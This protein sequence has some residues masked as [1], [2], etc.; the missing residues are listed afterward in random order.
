M[1]RRIVPNFL[2]TA[3][4]AACILLEGDASSRADILYVTNFGSDKIEKFTSGGSASV[5][6]SSG[7]SGP[8]GISF[9][10]TGNLFA[11]NLVG[12]TIEKYTLGVPSVFASGLN[13]P[14]G[15]AF[16]ATGNLYVANTGDR[17]IVKF[18]PGGARSVFA[19]TGGDNLGYSLAFDSAG[20]LYASSNDMI[21]K[22]SA[23]GT[24]LGPF[25][26]TGHYIDA[27]AFDKEGNLYA[28]QDNNTIEKLSPTGT[29][30]GV[31]AN[32]YSPQGLAF[33]SGGNLYVA[34]TNNQIMKFAPDGSGSFFALGV[35][36]YPTNL[37]FT[38][39]AGVPLPLANQVPEASACALLLLGGIG[40]LA[41]RRSRAMSRT[42]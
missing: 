32:V 7:L 38:N 12:N 16:D 19:T 20:I 15:L 31:F 4:A 37:A 8:W 42:S 28:G 40:M 17:T 9:D 11:A 24:A 39:D 30:L 1:N 27:L 5:F 29:D 21:L 18:T 10:L 26:S 2:P 3:I 36:S 41:A 13:L 6:A 33:D 25:V 23:A 34:E 35:L 14:G 22:F